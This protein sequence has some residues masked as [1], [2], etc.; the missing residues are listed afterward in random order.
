MSE[1]CTSHSSR[2]CCDEWGTGA[3]GVGGNR[4]RQGVTPPIAMGLRWA[5][6]F[7]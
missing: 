1:L 4:D 2:C 3:V 7:R 5:G 6:H